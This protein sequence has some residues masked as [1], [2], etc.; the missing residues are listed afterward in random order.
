MIQIGKEHQLFLDDFVLA[1]TRNID[2][3]VDP[4][5]KHPDNPLIKTTKTDNHPVV[6]GSVIP[7]EA[8]GYDMWYAS[9]MRKRS[10][11]SVNHAVSEDGI[12]W[13]K[14]QN[15][16]TP[17]SEG[18][19]QAVFGSGYVEHF[20][21]LFTVLRD[22]EEEDP[23]RR[24][25]ML[26]KTKK[27]GEPSPYR[28]EIFSN[29]QAVFADLERRGLLD[30]VSH[31]RK[32]ISDALYLPT[33]KRAAG[34]AFSPD[35]INW[36]ECDPFFIPAIGDL[37]HLTWDP[38]Q[39]QY[40]IFARD[41]FL[42]EEVHAKFRDT[43]WY[44][45]IFWGR[46]VRLYTSQ[47]FVHWTPGEMVM[48]ADIDDR[49]GDEIYSMAV[50]PYE[51][52]Y[53]GLIQMYHAFPGDNTLDIQLAVSRDAVRWQRVGN[54][55]VFLAL[56]GIGAWDRFNQSLASSPVMVDDEI[57]IYYGGRTWRHPACGKPYEGADTGPRLSGIG[58]ATVKR[59]RFVH[60]AASFD[61]GYAETPPLILPEGRLQVN[62]QSRFGTL[63]VIVYDEEGRLIP[64]GES[65][66]L[67]EDSLDAVVEWD[68][69]NLMEL[70]KGGSVRFRFELKNAK[71]YS[72]WIE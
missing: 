17:P 22:H 48:Y 61:G 20:S 19:P 25:K 54:R 38:Y 13:R 69:A 2:R 56:G 14:P 7:S 15:H 31:Y 43:E 24:Y 36:G 5:R 64:G 8:S 12:T 72:F 16:L 32:M 18:K 21:E 42:P 9:N 28:E 30:L 40:L 71:L 68:S 26:F 62:T 10:S 53:I 63:R 34:V 65:K 51:G 3:K 23:G 67:S 58:M 11:A 44:R 49:P 50:F 46:A 4:A 70:A 1:K 39:K 47:D 37:S 57:R 6:F 27:W 41:F 45:E 52:L 29:H 33:Q 60:L 35:G 59:D 55:E 66:P